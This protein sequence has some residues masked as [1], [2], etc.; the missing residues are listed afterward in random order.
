M[1]QNHIYQQLSECPVYFQCWHRL[2]GPENHMSL[3][4]S[5]NYMYSEPISGEAWDLQ[6]TQISHYPGLRMWTF[7][8]FSLKGVFDWQKMFIIQI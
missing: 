1:K 6:V 2:C 5:L 4:I 7:G 8:S 3:V